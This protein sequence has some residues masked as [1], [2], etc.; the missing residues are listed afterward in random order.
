MP[1]SEEQLTVVYKKNIDWFAKFYP[2]FLSSVT[3]NNYS[4]SNIDIDFVEGKQ[5]T[6]KVNGIQLT[7]RHNRLNQVIQQC[8]HLSKDVSVVHIY[9]FALGD[10]IE[11]LLGNYSSLK[12]IIVHVLNRNIFNF[13]INYIDLSTFNKNIVDYVYDE[14][15]HKIYFPNIISWSD[16]YLAD[17]SLYRLTERL[18]ILLNAKYT[19]QFFD[20]RY[21]FYENRFKE[22]M[23][24]IKNDLDVSTIFKDKQIKFWNEKDIVVVTSGPSVEQS[25]DKILKLKNDGALIVA[26]DTSTKILFENNIPIDYIISIDES[27]VSSYLYLNKKDSPILIYYPTLPFETIISCDKRYI[28][29]GVGKMFANLNKVIKHFPLFTSGSVAHTAIDFAIHLKPKHIYMFGYDFSYSSEKTHAGY[30]KSDSQKF[31]NSN[32]EIVKVKGQHGEWLNTNN[33]FKTYLRDL[34]DYIEIHK[35]VVFYN[36]SKTGAYIEGTNSYY[37]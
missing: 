7:S 34:E 28:A 22:N 31:L 2:K 11:Y 37:D 17:L 13:V 26:V 12:K 24:F 15:E 25:I 19:Q 3:S 9:G 35:N 5:S 36:M 4:D 16:V 23:E 30:T 6:L 14:H 21:S 33:V 20:N 8:E 1:N 10:A 27:I 29:Y 18:Q 32:M